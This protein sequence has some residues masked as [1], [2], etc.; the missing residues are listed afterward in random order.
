MNIVIG[1][2]FTILEWLADNS[3]FIQNYNLSQ[4]LL[5]F[6]IRPKRFIVLI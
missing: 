1:N 5:Y 4:K 2:K 6:K 3:I